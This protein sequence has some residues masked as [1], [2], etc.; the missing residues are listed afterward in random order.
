MNTKEMQDVH[1]TS[2][3]WKVAGSITRQRVLE[4]DTHHHIAG[5]QPAWQPSEYDDCVFECVSAVKRF[6]QSA[7][8]KSPF[9][10]LTSNSLLS[11]VIMFIQTY[12]CL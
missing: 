8:R 5:Q 11:L 7:D 9:V 4:Q 3:N 1:H 10:S 6:E 2:T 12:K